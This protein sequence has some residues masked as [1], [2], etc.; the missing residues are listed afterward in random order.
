MIFIWFSSKIDSIFYMTKVV[1]IYMDSKRIIKRLSITKNI[2]P[3]QNFM[4][5]IALVTFIILTSFNKRLSCTIHFA[6]INKVLVIWVIAINVLIITDKSHLFKIWGCSTRLR[7]R[8]G[9]NIFILFWSSWNYISFSRATPINKLFYMKSL[10]KT[11][12]DPAI[13]NFTEAIKS[14]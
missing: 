1:I 4:R 5:M 10:K 11:I 7:G 6:L 12:S 14:L 3:M 13:R 9:G 8:T 2:K